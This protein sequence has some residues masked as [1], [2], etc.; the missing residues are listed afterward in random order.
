MH[1][2]SIAKTFLLLDV[3][4]VLLSTIYH[5]IKKLFSKKLFKEVFWSQLALLIK[6]SI[7]IL[8]DRFFNLG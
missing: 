5:K 7:L 2:L 6:F 3:F 4:H 8:K 1:Q